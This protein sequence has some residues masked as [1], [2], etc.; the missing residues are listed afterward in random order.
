MTARRS[1]IR[2]LRTRRPPGRKP[3]GPAADDLR[4][5][6]TL[7]RIWIGPFVDAGGLYREAGWVRLVIEPA[8]WRRP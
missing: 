3:A 8:R 1:W 7:G 5:P 6:E 4:V 2:R